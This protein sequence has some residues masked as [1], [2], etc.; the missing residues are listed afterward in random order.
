MNMIGN[1]GGALG[2][3]AVPWLMNATQQNWDKIFYVAAATYLI[4]ALCWMFIDS[5]ERLVE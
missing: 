2:G 1:L 3:I 5:D 4:A